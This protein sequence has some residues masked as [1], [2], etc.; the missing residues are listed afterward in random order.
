[1]CE[2][3]RMSLGI[4]FHLV[5]VS[6]EYP[7]DTKICSRI[8]CSWWVIDLEA[9]L[10]IPASWLYLRNSNS[11]IHSIDITKLNEHIVSVVANNH[12]WEI[13][14]RR[15][16]TGSRQYFAL[17]TSNRHRQNF[18]GRPLISMFAQL[19]GHMPIAYNAYGWESMGQIQD[20]D[21]Y[22]ID[23]LTIVNHITSKLWHP[24][25][26]FPL[27]PIVPTCCTRWK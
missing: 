2:W 21:H 25:L 8:Q 22:T 11:Y 5:Q 10:C 3:F 27:R 9:G 14:H 17:Q 18:D 7:D 13:L 26:N 6:P 19:A 23:Q 20:G 24:S 1:M 16:A 4:L 15:H 12:Q